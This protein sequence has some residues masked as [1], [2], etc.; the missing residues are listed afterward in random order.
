MKM[1]AL[2]A[3]E[4]AAEFGCRLDAAGLLDR[5]GVADL[6]RRLLT[7]R[8]ALAVDDLIAA[9]AGLT[10]PGQ[11]MSDSTA[12]RFHSVLAQ[13]RAA[14][15]VQQAAPTAGALCWLA[16]PAAVSLPDGRT[17]LLGQDGETGDPIASGDLYLNGASFEAKRLIDHLGPPGYRFELKCLEF[18]GWRHASPEDLAATLLAPTPGLAHN[19]SLSTAARPWTETPSFGTIVATPDFEA[20]P[21]QVRR[22]L[23]LAGTPVDD[24]L[25]S[26][27]LSPL[28]AAELNMW[29]GR[30]DRGMDDDDAIA[31][32]GQERVLEASVSRRL[33][34]E[35]G[36]GSGKTRVA[37]GRVARLINGGASATRIFMISFTQAA[38]GELR[39]RIGN[40]LADSD[41]A[42]DVHI[43]TL[44]SIASGFRSGFG[45]EVPPVGFEA[46]IAEALALLNAGDR[47][48]IG[49]LGA[50]EHLVVDEAQDL[51]G[52]R[53]A[54]VEAL[55]RALPP[56]CGVTLF[57][58]P[59]QAI[60]GW[61]ANASLSLSSKLLAA[62]DM[63]FSRLV[64]EHDHRTRNPD[65]RRLKAELRTLLT[66]DLAPD[67]AYHAVRAAIEVAAEPS[68]VLSQPGPIARST[69]VLFRSRGELLSAA[70]RFWHEGVP[71]RVRLTR[72]SKSVVAWLGALLRHYEATSLSRDDF[73]PLW[74]DLWPRPGA[75]SADDA[76]HALR[77]VAGLGRRGGVDLVRLGR[78]I[79]TP[80]PPLALA[81]SSTGR[82]GPI[83]S[84]IHGSK[85]QEAEHVVLAL[86]RASETPSIEEARILFVAATRARTSLSVAAARPEFGGSSEAGRHWSRW[87]ETHA[88]IEIGLDGDVDVVRTAF[89]D[90]EDPPVTDARQKA[91]WRLSDTPVPVR[92]SWRS[93]GWDMIVDGGAFEGQ[94]L[95]FLS[96]RVSADLRSIGKKRH[97][98]AFPSSTL[99]GLFVVGSRT[100][101]HT[102]PGAAIRFGLVPVIAGLANVWF[103][104]TDAATPVEATS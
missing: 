86:P 1:R 98:G 84:T 103:N 46:G 58:D 104:S 21:D 29:T 78:R 43:S 40:F 31:D 89:P 49:F 13:M 6:I 18:P 94:D 19:A 66:S 77:G 80:S 8:G 82:T 75:L 41:L 96:S 7:T 38:V 50:L 99:H 42:G 76:W 60:Y 5:R 90:D 72:R 87:R 2:T 62:P 93:G 36:P 48:L 28:V 26:W 61:L 37:C 3:E 35:A 68:T 74:H 12:S 57:E 17:L 9:M 56:H 47:G 70:T 55:V 30:P 100:V 59:A 69:L 67:A 23:A 10:S 64:L 45:Q 65:L 22:A 85:G 44:D 52:D 4:V 11:S 33:V 91:L 73:E 20:L 27:R 51:I 97:G 24:A 39:T 88:R 102:A 16:P 92:C 81:R 14:G 15:E 54:L 83:L 95:G 79:D 53:G 25:S 101:V 34:V 63:A 71:V 32:V